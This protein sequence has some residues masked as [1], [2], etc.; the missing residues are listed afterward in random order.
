[1][2][3]YDMYLDTR[4]NIG[5][6]TASHWG[7][8]EVLRKLNANQRRVGRKLGMVLGDWLV[9]HEDLTPSSSVITLP[10]DCARPVYMEEKSSGCPIPNNTTVRERRASRGL[11]YYFEGNTLVVNKDSYSTVVTLWYQR[12]ILD[13]A[14]D[15]IGDTSSGE[16]AIVIA[17]AQFPRLL[18]DYY[19]G[20]MVEVVG[21]T[22]IGT[23]AEVT[24]YDGGTRKLT[25]TGTFGITSQWGTVSQ[26]P[27]ECHDLIVLMATLQLLAKPSSAIDPKYFEYYATLAA[28]A[29]KDFDEWVAT[30]R[31]GSQRTQITGR[32]DY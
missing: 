9:T 10:W 13:M 19:N 26:L 25:L 30:R 15:K 17:A 14:F 29:E 3:A 21:G 32:G 12:R 23:I 11:E 20:L 8:P 7:N 27:E 16:N 24:D 18:D 28:K 6:D 31:S 22:G 1:M 5:E 2:N 4:E